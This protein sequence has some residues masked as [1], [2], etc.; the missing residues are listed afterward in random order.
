MMLKGKE[1]KYRKIGKKECA[2]LKTEKK[3]KD[4]GNNRKVDCLIVGGAAAGLATAVSLKEQG[5]PDLQ[6]VVIEKNEKSGDMWRSR[7]ER[8]HLH[9][10][11]EE[12]SEKRKERK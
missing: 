2:E 4:D 9:D 1:M 6:V 5:N 8:L 3:K 11:I 12:V 7:Y 10:I